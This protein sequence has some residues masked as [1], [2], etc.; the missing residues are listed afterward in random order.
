M[1]NY[2][3]IIY[4]KNISESLYLKVQN[5]QLLKFFVYDNNYNHRT[6]EYVSV[7]VTNPQKIIIFLFVYGK[8]Y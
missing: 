2:Y 8:L 6:C 4:F 1:H 5:I 3:Y 7:F